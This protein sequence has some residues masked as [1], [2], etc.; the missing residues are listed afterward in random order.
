[1]KTKHQNLIDRINKAE[2]RRMVFM[3]LCLIVLLAGLFVIAF[4]ED[5]TMSWPGRIAAAWNSAGL[6]FTGAMFVIMIVLLTG[7]AVSVRCPH[8]KTPLILEKLAPIAIAT[9]HCGKCG[10]PIEEEETG[11]PASAGDAVNRAPEK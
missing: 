2:S 1:M 3:M 8:C 6:I 9:G 11:E 7:N 4:L 10:R 5:Q